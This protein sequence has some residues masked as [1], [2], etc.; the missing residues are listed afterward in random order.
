MKSD[1]LNVGQFFNRSLPNSGALAQLSVSSLAIL[2][3]SADIECSRFPHSRTS[4][5]FQDS[6]RCCTRTCPASDSPLFCLS[7]F[8]QILRGAPKAWGL[9]CCFEGS[10][11]LPLIPALTTVGAEDDPRMKQ[12]FAK[13]GPR[14]NC[15]VPVFSCSRV[16]LGLLA[17]THWHAALRPA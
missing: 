3:T 4:R 10:Y 2:E 5:L 16:S 12:R 1:A 6:Q 13:Q 11:F 7:V 17:P 9:F 14:E 8:I 15:P